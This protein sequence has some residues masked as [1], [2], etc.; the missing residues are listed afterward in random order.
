[1]AIPDFGRVMRP[2][3]ELTS[4]G[5]EYALKELREELAQFF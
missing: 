2:L 3:L 4:D 1:M 5:K